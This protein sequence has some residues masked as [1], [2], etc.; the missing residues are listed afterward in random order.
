MGNLKYVNWIRLQLFM[1]SETVSNNKMVCPEN[2]E[3][4]I[5]LL[6]NLLVSSYQL[7]VITVKDNKT[8]RL[9][10]LHR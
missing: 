8:L 7:L 3:A 1:Y 5:V 9:T 6:L 10:D 4:D 2:M